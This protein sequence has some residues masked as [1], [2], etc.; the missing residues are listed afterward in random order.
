MFDE[1]GKHGN[2]GQVS[3]PKREAAV[4][5]W[6]DS[7]QAALRSFEPAIRQLVNGFLDDLDQLFTATPELWG[8]LDAAGGPEHHRSLAAAHLATLLD[9]PRLASTQASSQHVGAAHIARAVPPSWYV[10][11]YNRLFPVLH[12]LEHSGV[13]LPPLDLLRK[14][15]LWDMCQTLDAYHDELFRQAGTDSLTGLANRRTIN[16]VVECATAQESALLLLDLDGFKSLNDRAGHL[17]GDKAL[18]VVAEALVATVRRGDV[19]ARLGGDEF[20]VWMPGMSTSVV[21][22]QCRRVAAALPLAQFG[23]TVSA[24][25]AV[26]PRDGTDFAALYGAADTALYQVKRHRR[27]ALALARGNEILPWTTARD[28]TAQTP[29]ANRA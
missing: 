1:D 22:A 8:V 15:W 24:G 27:A 18:S 12:R 2:E 11:A 10:T 29:A 17:E 9:D 20:C 19:V 23:L 13:E 14:R 28:T 25:V 16:K 4:V 21:V 6:S 3:C 5:S 7:E 26:W